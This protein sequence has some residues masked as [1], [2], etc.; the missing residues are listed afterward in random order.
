MFARRGE[1]FSAQPRAQR[2]IPQPVPAF[3]LQETAHGTDGTAPTLGTLQDDIPELCRC[4]M[5][6]S[7]GATTTVCVSHSLH[8]AKPSDPVSQTVTCVGPIC[9]PIQ[10]GSS[11]LHANQS[12]LSQVQWAMQS[13]VMS[14]MEPPTASCNATADGTADPV[15]PHP[16]PAL[17][18]KRKHCTGRDHHHGSQAE[19]PADELQEEFRP[20]AKKT[21]KALPIFSVSLP[22]EGHPSSSANGT[23]QAQ[24]SFAPAP[25]ST[26]KLQKSTESC[27][28]DGLSTGKEGMLQ[29][30]PLLQKC[31]EREKPSGKRQSK[32]KHLEVQRSRKRSFL[33]MD[34]P[35]DAASTC[36][37]VTVPRK[38]VKLS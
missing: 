36:D 8:K 29:P 13:A 6:L 4:F 20:K 21:C 18:M 33:R 5:Q 35:F 14:I 26:A 32:T 23:K 9:D 31:A 19:N 16:C 10:H 30:A 22:P 27:K 24:P 28:T 11:Q 34:D 2:A 38:V 12:Q 25:G 37:V 15:S 7:I 3:Q 1:D 17:R